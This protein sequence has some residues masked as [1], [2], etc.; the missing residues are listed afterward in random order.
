MDETWV[1]WQAR[2]QWRISLQ[3]ATHLLLFLRTG[4]EQTAW[5]LEQNAHSVVLEEKLWPLLEQ[6][7]LD[8]LQKLFHAQLLHEADKTGGSWIRC[9]IP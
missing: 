2:S 6:V 4:L 7:L 5:K 1:R 9:W 8:V 3:G